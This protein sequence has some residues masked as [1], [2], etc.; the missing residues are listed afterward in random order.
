MWIASGS[1]NLHFG[2]IL[3]YVQEQKVWVG[4]KCIKPLFE[5]TFIV[6][7]FVSLNVYGYL[8][9]HEYRSQCN[10]ASYT[11]LLCWGPYTR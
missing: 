5:K 10:N 4:Q 6:V 8:K 3:R 1:Y 2:A 7:A 11:Y 9:G